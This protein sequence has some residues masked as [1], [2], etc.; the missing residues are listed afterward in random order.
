MVCDCETGGTDTRF[1][2]L[3]AHFSH[4]DDNLE[5]VSSLDLK[6]KPDHDL[7]VVM[8]EAMNVNKIDLNS[9]SKTGTSYYDG[10]KVFSKFEQADPK[11]QEDY[12]KTYIL[13]GWNIGF[14]I[15]FIKK[16]MFDNQ[17]SWY[18]E[19]FNYTSFDVKSVAI[20]L[21]NLGLLPSDF[22]LSL[23]N[24]AKHFNIDASKAH[25]AREDCILTLKVLKSLNQLIKPQESNK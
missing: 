16:Y 7:F 21:Q 22:R 10:Y 20:N 24:L 2:L 14:D 3:T 23:P 19:F 8:P 11:Q 18:Q 6:F 17:E 12:E 1:S 4:L 5:I 13:V 9:H 15:D 25:N